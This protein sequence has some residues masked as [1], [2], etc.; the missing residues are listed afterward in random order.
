[1]KKTQDTIT[2][3]QVNNIVPLFI[4]AIAIASFYFSLQGDIRVINNKLDNIAMKQDKLNSQAEDQ[5]QYINSLSLKVN[6][7]E[8]KIK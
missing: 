6:T 4:T 1:M 7:L 5:R 3:L 2:W 8:N